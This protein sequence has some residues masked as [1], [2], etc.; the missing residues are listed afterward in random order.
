MTNAI[1]TIA[2]AAAASLALVSTASADNAFSFTDADMGGSTIEL[3]Q[4]RAESNGVVSLYDFHRGEQ[5]VLLG[6][7]D[8]AGGANFDVR[9]KLKRTPINDV[10]AVLTVDGAV[11]ATQEYDLDR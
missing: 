6:T 7:Q 2:L 5:G 4:V 9:V 8:V 11:V 3:G 10:V 1:K